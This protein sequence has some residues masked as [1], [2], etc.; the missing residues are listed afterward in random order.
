MVE[1]EKQ[2][3][4]YLSNPLLIETMSTETFTSINVLEYNF[5]VYCLLLGTSKT[6]SRHIQSIKIRFLGDGR[7]LTAFIDRRFQTT[8]FEELTLPIHMRY[9]I[10][11]ITYQK[12]FALVLLFLFVLIFSC[13]LFD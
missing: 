2:F 5:D 6:D 9:A 11:S 10:K 4:P 1:S 13:S 12:M 3:Q 7:L 8:V